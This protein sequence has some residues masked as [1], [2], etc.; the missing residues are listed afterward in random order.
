MVSV[1]LHLLGQFFTLWPDI[2][3]QGSLRSAL[4]VD[5]LTTNY[6]WMHEGQR[7]DWSSSDDSAEES[8]LNSLWGCCLY[9][10]ERS[11]M[12]FGRVG[13]V[14]LRKPGTVR[15]LKVED[16]GDTTATAKEW[17]AYWWAP[18]KANEKHRGDWWHISPFGLT[19][20]LLIFG[21]LYQRSH[22]LVAIPDNTACAMVN[23][24]DSRNIG[25]GKSDRFSRRFTK[26]M[27]DT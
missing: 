16:H 14:R 6:L 12:L 5:E 1:I 22:L 7:I 8:V 4:K 11:G 24:D 10:L 23:D 3:L 2:P 27:D 25:G 17:T 19:I 9:Q 20:S 18:V 13:I 15:E 21:T 26:V